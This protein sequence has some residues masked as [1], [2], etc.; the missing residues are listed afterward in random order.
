MSEDTTQN[1][2]SV[3]RQFQWP[4]PRAVTYRLYHDDQ[5]QPLF[6][7]M[8]EL[9]GTYIEVD[10]RTY[11]R[12]SYQ[13]LVQDSKLILLE[14]RIQVSKLAPDNDHG[15]A[16]DHRDVCVVVDAGRPHQ[17]WRKITNDID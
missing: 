13:V 11:V 12:A 6:Y 3:L 8:D 17:K 1:F 4:E 15:V 14:P 16:C 10:Q 5:G 7:T 9:P 2:W